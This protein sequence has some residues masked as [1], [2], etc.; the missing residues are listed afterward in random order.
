MISCC[1]VGFKNLSMMDIRLLSMT[2][3]RDLNSENIPSLSQS[4]IPNQDL[5]FTH[6]LPHGFI[7]HNFNARYNICMLP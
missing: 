5:S 3:K 4:V 1:F 6:I 7:N 2:I